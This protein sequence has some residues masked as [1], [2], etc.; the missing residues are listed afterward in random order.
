MTLYHYSS[1]QGIFGIIN[2]DELHCSNINFLNDPSEQSYFSELLESINKDSAISR[3]ICETLFSASFISSYLNPFDRY[4]ASFSKNPDSLSMWNYYAKGNGYNIGLDIDEIIKENEDEN[5]SIQKVELIYD[6]DRQMKDTLEFILQYEKQ[7]NDYHKLE[8]AI[9]EMEKEEDYMPLVMEMDN[10]V[11]LF[12]DGLHKLTL[13]YKHQA[14]E[15]EEEVRLLISENE[16][17]R[18]S[19]KFKISENGVF[20]EYFSLK[21]KLRKNLKAVTIHPLCNE[22]HLEGTKRFI[23]SKLGST[24]RDIKI[25]SIPF[26]IV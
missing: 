22:V 1:G 5:I 17:E 10:I 24:K 3:E 15:R 23:S 18:R 7:S 14:Y 8:E 4:V 16:M 12:N 6:I 13:G 20:I 21:L 25:S 26:R 2:S 9:K 19:T 11:E